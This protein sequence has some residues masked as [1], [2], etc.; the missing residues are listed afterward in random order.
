MSGLIGHFYD[1]K[2]QWNNW[3]T[4]C[5]ECYPLKSAEFGSRKLR[6]FYFKGFIFHL[7]C[8][9]IMLSLATYT[10]WSH[11]PDR[12]VDL[13]RL[14]RG[15]QSLQNSTQLAFIRLCLLVHV[16][17]YIYQNVIALCCIITAVFSSWVIVT[18]L[19]CQGKDNLGCDN[20]DK[21]KSSDRSA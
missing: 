3:T 18:S 12:A 5:V 17:A 7:H 20:R 21:D 11:S 2:H 13:V 10:S 16:C 8:Y 1:R 15:R 19:W 6:F 4:G 9:S 14:S